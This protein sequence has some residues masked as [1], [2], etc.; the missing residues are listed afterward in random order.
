MSACTYSECAN[1]ISKHIK[2][3]RCNNTQFCS[4]DC[5]IKHN[6]EN[7]QSTQEKIKPRLTTLKK[8]DKISSITDTSNYFY[9]KNFRF[10]KRQDE[11]LILKKAT[12]YEIIAVKSKIDEKPY[13]M[14]IINK[15]KVTN[16]RAI[17]NEIR[18]HLSIE[19]DNIARLFGYSENGEHLFL[20]LEYGEKSNL[21]S[22]CKSSSSSL[23]EDTLKSY[24][25]CILNSLNYLYS[26][27]VNHN[28][29]CI[30][31]YIVFESAVVKL[32][33][34]TYTEDEQSKN[35]VDIWSVGILIYEMTQ[36][37]SIADVRLI[38]LTNMNRN[39]K[40]IQVWALIA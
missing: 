27:G 36:G 30:T 33:E 26:K 4:H 16:F 25:R 37:L 20:I 23:D 14:K 29:I 10:I 40:G 11:K 21:A 9:F 32:W 6:F 1:D 15:S 13:A 34:F 17:K 5:L 7:H 18:I 35:H 31:N 28:N 3:S 12:S 22:L 39:L 2:C 38:L 24:A 19:H 8:H